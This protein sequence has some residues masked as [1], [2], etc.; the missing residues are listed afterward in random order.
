[1]LCGQISQYNLKPDDRYGVKNL[2]ILVQ[3]QLKME[4]FLVGTIGPKYSEEH[5]KVRGFSY[6]LPDSRGTNKANVSM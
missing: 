4:G 3:R 5:Q 1:M 2:A 6:L